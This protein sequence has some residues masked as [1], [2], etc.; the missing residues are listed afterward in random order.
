ML[1]FRE[2]SKITKIC[3]VFKMHLHYV[4]SF[5]IG[6]LIDGKFGKC[7]NKLAGFSNDGFLK[8]LILYCTR[9]KIEFLIS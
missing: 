5:G 6:E 3:Y 4:V 7:K 8:A 2:S 9:M 1:D